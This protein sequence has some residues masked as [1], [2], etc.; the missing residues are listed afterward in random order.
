MW[1]TL[2]ERSFKQNIRRNIARKHE[3]ECEDKSGGL[4]DRFDKLINPDIAIIQAKPKASDS[5]QVSN[6]TV[7]TVIFSGT[8]I[9]K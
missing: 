3:T 8:E 2:C 9:N 4:I 6:I 7:P 5:L 1:V